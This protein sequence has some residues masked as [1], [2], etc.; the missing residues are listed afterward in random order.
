V[1]SLRDLS[2]K[3][4]LILG[5]LTALALTVVLIV[6]ASA[7]L[8]DRALSR[9]LES[10]ARL[11]RPILVAALAAPLAQR[12]YA[13]VQ[14]ILAESR[15][16][17][18][19][20]YLIVFDRADSLVAAEGWK[21]GDPAPTP[22]S[23]TPSIGP[24]G[25]E[26]YDYELPIEVAGQRLGKVCY[27]VSADA[28]TE[29]RF[30]LLRLSAQIGAVGA[31]GFLLL[32]VALGYWLVRP[33][34]RLTQASQSIR[35]GNY[36]IALERMGK[37]EIGV[38]A[39]NFQHMASEVKSRVKALTASE[40]MQKRYVEEA[41]QRESQLAHA[42]EQAEAASIAKTQF[43]AKV[44][45][46][47]RTPL[48]GILGMLELLGESTLSPEQREQVRIAH[49]SGASLLGIVNDILDFSRG[50]AG[51]LRFERVRFSVRE[52]ID[53]AAKLYREMAEEKGVALSLSLAADVP[54]QVMGDPGRVRQILLNLVANAV[55]FTD[56]G[57][58]TI[59]ARGDRSSAE[60][61]VLSVSITDTGTGIAREIQE[62]LFQPFSQGD[63]SLSRRFGG[64]GLGLAISRQLAQAMGGSID[65]E[66]VRGAGSTFR[67]TLPLDLAPASLAGSS[68]RVTMP[69]RQFHAHLLLVEDNI[70]NRMVLERFVRAL[71]CTYRSVEHGQAA[72]DAL[73]S[74]RFDALLMDLQMPVMD[75]IEAIRRI[76]AHERACSADRLTAIAVTAHA[77]PEERS[78]SL[79]AG[80]DDF[81]TK[82]LNIAALDAALG[83]W[84]APAQDIAPDVAQQA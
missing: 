45:H 64:T 75:G 42:K 55:K 26:R 52:E 43:L 10:R 66:S 22:V 61:C 33:L 25:K 20:A 68:P 74:E 23:R 46:E 14:Q 11:V 59:E 36:D 27:G 83:R 7:W 38:L 63:D 71:G 32:L 51:V 76:R 77:L 6:W 13:T 39:E 15:H 4:K 79:E 1:A 31:T 28:L 2:F 19:L 29:A 50:E 57:S 5:G 16:E 70:V 80:Y 54:E 41:R 44:S 49:R 12:D 84:F 60:R 21:P 62:K 67:L 53:E 37:D 81:L 48:N 65:I 34:E 30:T 18:G 24:D 3:R 78:R 47:I 73:A 69:R 9:E 8:L 72:I 58:V 17:Q 35:A 56:Q 82:P 40:A